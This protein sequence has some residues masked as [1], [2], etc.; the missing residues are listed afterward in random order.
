[1]LY[2]FFGDSVDY[3]ECKTIAKKFK[4]EGT[5]CLLILILVLLPA[6]IVAFDRYIIKKNKKI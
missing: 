6:V 5:L 2:T 3:E 4:K 1:M